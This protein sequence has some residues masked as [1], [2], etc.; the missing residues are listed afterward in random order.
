M[1][2]VFYTRTA[3]RALRKHATRAAG[4]RAKIEQYAADPSSLANNVI[5]MTGVDARQLRV[6][7]FRV[8]FLEAA[9]S[10]TVL[11]IGPRGDIYE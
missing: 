9:E 4:I 6:G 2:A 3:A 7:D 5:V 11:D 1:K 10:I 8:I